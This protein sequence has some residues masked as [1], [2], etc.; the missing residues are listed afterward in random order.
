MLT[1]LSFESAPGNT[2]GGTVTFLVGSSAGNGVTAASL[3][4][5]Y[6]FEGTE[7][8][9]MQAAGQHERY[10]Y[11]RRLVLPLSG[12]IKAD[13]AANWASTRQSFAAKLLPNTG[14]QTERRHGTLKATFTGQSQVYAEVVCRE[15]N[16]P[17]DVNEGGP[18]VSEYSLR[19]V[20]NYGYWRLVSTN[21]VLKI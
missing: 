3:D 15:L 9:K 18:F 2:T 11:V 1:A 19:F 13:T 12:L 17:M 10:V 5:E 21:A 16:L 4:Q 8:P 14:T 6:E 7:K 20:A